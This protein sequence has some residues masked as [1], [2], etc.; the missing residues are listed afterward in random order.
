[1][2]DAILVFNA[3]SSSIKFALFETSEGGDP[4]LSCK[5]LLDEDQ[6]DPRLVVKDAGGHILLE[7]QLTQSD[8]AEG[9]LFSDV[10][11][12][13]ESRH[14][15]L[16]AIGHRVVHGG[17]KFT[18]AVRVS[19]EV[20]EEL[21]GLT[22][23]APLHQPRCLSP[24][25]K[26]NSLRP[27]LP[28][29]ACFDTAFH[30]GIEPPVSRFALP[31]RFEEIGIR[32]YGFH[33][34]SYEYIA[35]R[36]AGLSPALAAARTVVAHLGNGASLCA[37]QNGRS[38]DTTMGLTALDGVVMGTRCGAIDPGVLLY[39][40]QA[41]QMSAADVERLLYRESGLLGVSGISHDVRT[42]LASDDPRAA[43][44]LDLFAFSVTRQVSAMANSLGGLD[45][46]VFTGGIG[47]HASAV[48]AAICARLRWLGV[49]LDSEANN[50]SKSRISAKE[51]RI[52]VRVI[53][54]DEE[55]M[56]ARHCLTKTR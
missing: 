46:L 18:T 36:L 29:F 17:R 53:P 55:I 38:V 12:W 44:A 9:G 5:G 4:R 27:H 23:L 47:E 49:E 54:T 35:S 10:I 28:Q 16:A 19:Q 40:Q 56:I 6:E 33:G 41:M 39:L 2:S 13:V 32:R 15:A 11:D 21:D 26:I 31:R 30:Y 51:S 8:A 43:E 22:P 48:R 34:L 7:R 1:M 52:D 20:I 14:K 24:M 3:G 25:R 37:M 42:L 45:C 50:L